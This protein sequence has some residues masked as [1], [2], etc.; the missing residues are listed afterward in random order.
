MKKGGLQ[1]HL[2]KLIQDFE[3]AHSNNKGDFERSFNSIRSHLKRHSLAKNEFKEL[4]AHYQNGK[5]KKDSRMHAYHFGRLILE[6][7]HDKNY[8]HDKETRKRVMR[9][10]NNVLEEIFDTITKNGCRPSGDIRQIC[11]ETMVSIPQYNGATYEGESVTTALVGYLCDKIKDNKTN[12]EKEKNFRIHGIEALGRL[13]SKLRKAERE[14]V[15]EAMQY[16]TENKKDYAPVEV[17]LA[18]SV[19]KKRT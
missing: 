1:G 14:S 6:F 3:R 19:L 5:K 10:A 2:E 15:K 12:S 16:V 7:A 17:R 8:R 9:I 4:N 18:K 11:L 13:Y